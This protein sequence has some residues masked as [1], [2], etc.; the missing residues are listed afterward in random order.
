MR[1]VARRLQDWLKPKPR[2]ADW[3]EYRYLAVDLELSSLDPNRG[4]ILSIGW[5]P[6]KPPQICQGQGTELLI[7]DPGDLGQSPVIHGLTQQELA[8]GIGLKQALLQLLEASRQ[9]SDN[10]WILHHSALD[11]AFIQKACAA[12][13]I[14]FCVPRIVD[15]LRLEKR[16]LTRQGKHPQFEGLTLDKCRSRYGLDSH[17]AH[18]ALEDALAT[19]ELFLCHAYRHFG[20]RDSSLSYLLSP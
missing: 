6:V 13:D 12:C 3:R 4:Q 18:A 17:P 2:L 19:A 1:A 14:E 10:I 5:L 11:M 16:L 8:K 15:T 7:K 9:H 20:G